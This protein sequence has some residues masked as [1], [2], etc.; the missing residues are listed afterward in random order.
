M[1]CLAITREL[2]K[3]SEVGDVAM[4]TALSAIWAALVLTN[5]MAGKGKV[6]GQAPFLREDPAA[7]HPTNL[8]LGIVVAN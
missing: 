3:L 1:A 7:P 8:L 6:P 4:I 5:K 2:L